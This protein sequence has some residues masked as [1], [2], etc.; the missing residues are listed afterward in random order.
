MNKQSRINKN[1]WEYRAYEFW[2]RRDGSPNE[3]AKEILKNPKASLK[4]HQEYFE[5]IDGL[6]VANI[7][8]SNGRKAVPL[9]LMGADVTVFDISEENRKYA[10]ELARCANT[11]ITYI[12]GDVYEADVKTY[13]D[14]FDVIYMEGG[15]LHYFDDINRLMK[16]L[17]SILKREGRLILSDYHPLKRC[18]SSDFQYIPR[19]FDNELQQAD[20]SYKQFF[21]EQ[22]QQ[23]F[24]DV[25]LRFYTLSEIFNSVVSTG[26]SLQRFDEHRGWNGEDIPWE[27]TV[28]ATKKS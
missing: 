12:V 25:S 15:V 5:E 26:F 16:V 10:L 8:G 1:A 21:P 2:N 28:L 22:E 18:I 24:P 9:S 4:K 7:C 3:K 23:D 13:E 6:R 14:H 17:F 19:Y 20:L 11:D 27:F